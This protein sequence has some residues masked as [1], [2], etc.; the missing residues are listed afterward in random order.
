MQL[1]NNKSV[2]SFIKR[3]LP[4]HYHQVVFEWCEAD[5]GKDVYEIDWKNGKLFLKGN[6]PVSIAAALGWYLKD[7]AN[8]NLSWCGSNMEL[9]ESLPITPYVRHVIEQKY[10]VYLN[11][12]TVNYS[13]S[14]WKWDR[15]EKEI[16]YM[17]LNGIN[18]VLCSVG[19]EAVWYETLLQMGMSDT[20]IRAFLCGPAFSAWQWM[21]NIEGFAG[22]MPKKWIESHLILGQK[23]M[24]RVLEF[25]MMPIQQGFSGY[26]P[27]K[28][29]ELYPDSNIQI[30]KVWCGVSES[31]QLDPMDEL[32]S[33]M[34]TCFFENMKKMFGLHGFYAADPFHEGEAPVDGEEYLHAVGKN[35]ADLIHGVDPKGIWMMM[36][37]SIQKEIACAVPKDQLL[38][39]DLNGTT[40]KEKENF[41]GY[42]FVAGIL[43][44]FGGRIKLHGD[45]KWLAENQYQLIRKQGLNV[46]GSG[47]FMEGISQNPAYYDLAFEMMTA[48]NSR[49]IE[50]WMEKYAERRYGTN[51][52]RAA[53][54]WEILLK[55][56]YAPG[57]NSVETSSIVSARPAVEVKKSGPNEGFVF[58]YGN[59]RLVQALKLLMQVDSK[60]DGYYFDLV[61]ILRQAMS[62]EAYEVY[63][64]ISKAFLNRDVVELK[65]YAEKFLTM[66]K[67]LD[68][69]TGLRKEYRFQEWVSDA[70]EYGEN[71]EEKDLYEYNATALLT[72]WGPDESTIIFD[73]AWREWSGL[74]GQYYAKRWEMFFNYL[75][76]ILER[77]EEYVELGIPQAFGREAWRANEFY[78]KLADFEVEWICSRKQFEESSADYQLIGELVEKYFTRTAYEA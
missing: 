8:V 21:T 10:R 60:T 17:A 3:V 4:E 19:I 54:A 26:I 35:I 42:P 72:I 67:E 30:K 46:C 14:W 5:D 33:K 63:R 41:W 34:G 9:P 13:A 69:L 74:I 44:N 53:E 55:T 48:E 49:D 52:E 56:V 39:L 77:D 76:G 15:W 59:Q 12:C 37:W 27:T 29:Q 40:Y 51:D 58:P 32:F 45:M 78:N 43:H 1:E 28:M 62:N 61:D 71:P 47:L 24:N 36:A 65:A 73:Y 2:E 31:A 6:S 23:I 70:R 66:L 38:I 50:T 68:Q 18:M 20:D 22:P 64:K 25:G 75:Q 57:T 7:T 11:Y 16:D